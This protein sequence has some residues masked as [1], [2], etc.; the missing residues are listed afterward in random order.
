MVKLVLIDSL[1]NVN[2]FGWK[3]AN[4]SCLVILLGAVLH[5]HI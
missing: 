3:F 1:S 2:K 5:K 4:S